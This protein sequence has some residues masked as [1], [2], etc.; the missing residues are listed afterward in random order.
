MIVFSW[1]DIVMGKS[2]FPHVRLVNYFV[3]LNIIQLID[4]YALRQM[5]RFSAPTFRTNCCRWKRRSLQPWPL[6]GV[7]HGD[8]WGHLCGGGGWDW[9][10]RRELFGKP[11]FHGWIMLN[12]LNE[13]WF[14]DQNRQFWWWYTH[15]LPWKNWASGLEYGLSL[16][17]W[18]STLEEPCAP[19]Q[20][21]LLTV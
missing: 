16:F 7:T 20:P 14:F 9:N 1:F 6:S 11:G 18:L 15:G 17:W 13:S 8:T 2:L 19:G 12:Q 3:L 10:L 5:G 21:G 4:P